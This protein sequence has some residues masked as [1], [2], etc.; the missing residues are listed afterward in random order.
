MF[1]NGVDPNINAGIQR[2]F[3]LQIPTKYQYLTGI[4]MVFIP[5]VGFFDTILKPM[6]SPIDQSNIVSDQIMTWVDK[7]PPIA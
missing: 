7:D 3:H 6:H 2:F 5:M 1:C 4:T